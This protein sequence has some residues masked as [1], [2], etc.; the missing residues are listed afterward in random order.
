ML[1]MA[2]DPDFANN[3]RI[4]TCFNV[5]ASEVQVVVWTIDPG[6]T[7]ATRVGTLLGGLPANSSGRL[8]V[9]A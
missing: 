7:S 8:R 4:Y 1:G 2:I 5:S 9:F 3:R 6:I